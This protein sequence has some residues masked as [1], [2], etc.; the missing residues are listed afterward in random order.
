MMICLKRNLADEKGFLRD[1]FGYYKN[2]CFKKVLGFFH[3]DDLVLFSHTPII[4]HTLH[5]FTCAGQGYN[6]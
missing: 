1:T 2:F 6:L 5:W 4:P 3:S